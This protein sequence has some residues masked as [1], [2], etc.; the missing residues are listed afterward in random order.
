[1]R[2]TEQYRRGQLYCVAK[3]SSLETKGDSGVEVLANEPYHDDETGQDGQ[4]TYKVYHLG[5]RLPGW[6]AALAPAGA[7]KLEERAWNAFPYCKTELSVC[8]CACSTPVHTRC[9]ANLTS[10]SP[11]PPL[12][13][14]QLPVLGDRFTFRIESKYFDDDLGAQENVRAAAQLVLAAAAAAD[15]GSARFLASRRLTCLRVRSTS[16]TSP[17]RRSSRPRTTRKTPTLPSST[18]RRPAVAHWLRASGRSVAL[19]ASRALVHL[20][21]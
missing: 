13:A 20:L 18:Q 1:M 19:A 12:S 6:I 17:T 5:S 4:Y 15:G 16:K 10:S 8:A 14:R 2:V 11:P 9:T 3:S 21:D 7:L